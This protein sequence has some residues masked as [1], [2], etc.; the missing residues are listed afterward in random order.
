ML[1]KPEDEDY[2]WKFRNEGYHFWAKSSV[3]QAF[4]RLGTDFSLTQA[5]EDTYYKLLCPLFQWDMSENAPNSGLL[6]LYLERLIIQTNLWIP[7]GLSSVTYTVHIAI[8]ILESW[9]WCRSI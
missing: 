8:M 4:I 1:D 7:L 3:F 5:L 9:S 2:H 6:H